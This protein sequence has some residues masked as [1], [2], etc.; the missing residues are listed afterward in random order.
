MVMT[1]KNGK[2]VLHKTYRGKVGYSLASMAQTKL[3]TSPKQNIFVILHAMLAY[4]AIS[5]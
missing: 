1:T 4:V 3:M 5:W 2:N